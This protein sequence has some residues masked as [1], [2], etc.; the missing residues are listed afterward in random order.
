MDCRGAVLR[1]IVFGLLAA[2]V[3]AGAVLA[4]SQAPDPVRLAVQAEI[5]QA[6]APDPED[7]DAS[8]P[9]HKVSA[10]MFHRV[11]VNDD[12][13]TDWV[14]DY[15]KSPNGSYFC[16]TGGCTQDIYVS[17]AAGGYD[18]VM[19]TLVREF[20]LR[21]SKGRTLLDVDFHGSVCGG[22]GVDPCPR[23]YVW[24]EATS[25]FV[26]RPRPKGETFMVGGPVRLATPSEASLPAPVRAAIADRTNRCKAVG[27]TYPYDLANITDVGDLNGDSQDDWVVGG[28]YDGCSFADQAPDTPPALPV[29]VFV[30]GPGGYTRAW[31]DDGPIWGLDLAGGKSTFVTLSGAEECGLNGKDCKRTYWRWNGSALVSKAAEQP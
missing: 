1:K 29:T 20:K 13:V 17:N 22:F 7:A 21:R 31:Q 3:S 10:A 11:N 12:G 14:A 24:S 26:S 30:S 4:A 16:G 15:G 19:S 5:D 27:G 2:L 23:S 28:G 18:R 8:A 6:M 25:R 9:P